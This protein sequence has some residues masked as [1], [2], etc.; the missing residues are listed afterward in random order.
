[1]QTVDVRVS[2]NLWPWVK[3]KGHWKWYTVVVPMKG[4]NHAKLEETWYHNLWKSPNVKVSANFQCASVISPWMQNSRTKLV[5]MIYAWYNLYPYQISTWWHARFLRYW[6][7]LFCTN[8]DPVTQIKVK[9][10]QQWYGSVELN[11][12]YNCTKFDLAR[13]PSI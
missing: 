2:L 8:S 4:Y 6:N 11:C 12:G 13:Y 10:H 3:V 9:G 5:Y 1:M 7:L